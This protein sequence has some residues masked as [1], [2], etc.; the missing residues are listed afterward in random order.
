VHG[1]IVIRQHCTFLW[2]QAELSYQRVAE[3][4]P[5]HCKICI[6]YLVN[7]CGFLLSDRRKSVSA[8]KRD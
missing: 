3:V 7:Q 8:S 5:K 1:T 6:D 2:R 4:D